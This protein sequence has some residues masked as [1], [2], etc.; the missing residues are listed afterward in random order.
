M[1]A[2]TDPRFQL[3]GAA[4]LLPRPM[5]A[6]PSLRKRLRGKPLLSL[7]VLT[8][9]VGGCLFAGQISNRDPTAYYLQNLS[10]P[11]CADFY[12]GTD[13]LGRDL[14][15]MVWYG[16]R[17]SLEIGLLSALLISLIGVVY[18][19]VSG[20]VG[21]RVDRVMMR[22]AELLGSIP[23]LLLVLLLTAVMG[24]QNALI[25]SLV[26]GGT[27]WFG[28]ARI[29]RS[30]VRQIRRSE[31]VLSARCMGIPFEQIMLRHLIPNF[32]SPILFVII[33]S[34]SASMSVESTLSFLGLGLPVEVLSWGSM[35]SLANRALLLNSWW[36]IVIPGLFLVAT[37]GSITSLAGYFRRESRQ[38]SNL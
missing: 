37:L 7:L 10:Q 8:L 26:I 5:P 17:V 20:M 32:L 2:A 35:L 36:V 14:F 15:S 9:V 18:G 19:C 25:L 29:V 23:S 16:G 24:R 13:S 6:K 34:I 33:S 1:N 3:A 22:L 12:F 30:E 38:H 27:G 21:G 4:P 11:P 31:Y 28:L